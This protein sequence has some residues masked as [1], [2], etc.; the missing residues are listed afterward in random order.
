MGRGKGNSSL[1]IYMQQDNMGALPCCTGV[2]RR[3]GGG[4][5]GGWC[6]ENTSHDSR[7]WAQ[8]G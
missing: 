2:E 8:M 6:K 4:G 1:S 3:R 5:G 7:E